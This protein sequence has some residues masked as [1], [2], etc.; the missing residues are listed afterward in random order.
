MYKNS[1]TFIILK[2]EEYVLIIKTDKYLNNQ[3]HL[4][5]EG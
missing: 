1:K 4:T 2:E 5:D 3:I